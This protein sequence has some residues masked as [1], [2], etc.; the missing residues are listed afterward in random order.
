MF[1]ILSSYLLVRLTGSYFL[2]LAHVLAHCSLILNINFFLPLPLSLFLWPLYPC[3]SSLRPILTTLRRRLRSYPYRTTWQKL[4]SSSTSSSATTRSSTPTRHTESHT[5]TPCSPTKCSSCA[6]SIG[7][8]G[9]RCCVGISSMLFKPTHRYTAF[10]TPTLGCHNC[11]N[12]VPL[13]SFVTVLPCVQDVGDAS[14]AIFGSRNP[15]Q[16]QKKRGLDALARKL[17]EDIANAV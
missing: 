10:G 13:C 14:S 4:A 15:R 16:A 12:C 1:A 11:H 3:H 9:E 17:R 8:V 7:C 6:T 2:W 5:T